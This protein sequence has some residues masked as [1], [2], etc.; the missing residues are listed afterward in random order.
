M[1]LEK[2][3]KAIKEEKERLK[4]DLLSGL[5][6]TKILS[7]R[8]T[9]IESMVDQFVNVPASVEVFDTLKDPATGAI[10]PEHWRL[11][12]WR[13]ADKF[14]FPHSINEVEN[15]K[16]G[17]KFIELGAFVGN[18]KVSLRS[19][20]RVEVDRQN[21]VQ[22][23]IRD[24]PDAKKIVDFVCDEFGTWFFEHPV[25][26]VFLSLSPKA[27]FATFLEERIDMQI[28]IRISQSLPPDVE[29]D[30]IPV[31]R[32]AMVQA[33]S[34]LIALIPVVGNAVAAYEAYT[35]KDIFGFRLTDLERGILAASVLLPI[36]GRL[37]KF[38]RALYT[39]SRLVAMYG[40]DAATWS[41]A[42]R[43][44]GSATIQRAQRKSIKEGEASVRSQARLSNALAT[45]ANKGVKDI[46]TNP[47]AIVKAADSEVS[48]LFNKL[49][50]QHP[51]LKSLDELSLQRIIEKGPNVDHLK[52]QLLEEILESKIIPI[53]REQRVAEALGLSVGRKRLEFIAGHLIRDTK[54]KQITDGVLAVRDGT[55]IEIVAVFEAKAGKNAAREL[56]LTRTSKSS[57]TKAEKEELRAYAKD[58]FREE[59]EIAAEK[60]VSFNKTL[61]QVEDE[62][63]LNELGGQVVRDI[64]R[65][66]AN[67]A[68]KIGSETVPIKFSRNKT[69]FFGVV[70]KDVKTSS[71][72]TELAAE[73]VKFEIIGMDVTQNDLKIVSQKLKSLAEKFTKKNL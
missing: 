39:E 68:L 9:A 71:I 10:G 23:I 4:K 30:N 15:L 42:V 63:L 8:R 16:Y 27:L 12:Q 28:L 65:L 64:E 62:I 49:I 26:R 59:K 58:V 45:S 14:L 18:L 34:M 13:E 11:F 21:G 6:N 29:S 40:R 48:S 5:L 7:I 60:G 22:F 20:T 73:N 35:G 41:R 57:L 52:G 24:N 43:D 72:E 47:S 61:E 55:S 25:D 51:F 3:E 17:Q 38:G 19:Q 1:S 67:N 70:P 56:S 53:L 50:T 69:K 37:V 44:G 33:A 31:D 32:P 54:G 66:S 36:A 46:V 2:Y